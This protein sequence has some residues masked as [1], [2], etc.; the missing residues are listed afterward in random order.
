MEVS[1]D[2]ADRPAGAG[3]SQ[4]KGPGPWAWAWVRRFGSSGRRRE[5]LGSTSDR[6]IDAWPL[7]GR[8]CACEA[9]C[10]SL[11]LLRSYVVPCVTF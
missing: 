8:T 3:R 1:V 10:R 2:Q 6:C 5:T 4:Y 7:R 9:W 11:D